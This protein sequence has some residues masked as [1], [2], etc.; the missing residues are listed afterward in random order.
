MNSANSLLPHL[1]YSGVKV[2]FSKTFEQQF[3]ENEMA[4]NRFQ[5]L[6]K[7]YMLRARR[8]NNHWPDAV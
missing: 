4:N 5:M 3:E 2:A 8:M 1:P 7:F 6:N